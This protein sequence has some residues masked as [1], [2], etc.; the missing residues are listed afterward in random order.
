MGLSNC[1][2]PSSSSTKILCK[3]FINF[4]CVIFPAYVIFRDWVSLIIFWGE[5]KYIFSLGLEMRFQIQIT[6]S[7][8]HVRDIVDFKWFWLWCI[9]HRITG[10][11]DFFHRTVFLGVKTRRFGNR[12]SF[13]NV[14]FLLPRT[15]DGGKCSKPQ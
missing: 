7:E 4:M 3:H 12:S 14:V 5:R 13:R 6:S 11:L 8:L 10:V 9:A 1:L 15:L 2:L